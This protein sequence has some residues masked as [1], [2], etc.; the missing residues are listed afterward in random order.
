MDSSGNGRPG[1]GRW[2]GRIGLAVL[3]VL[4][5]GLGLAA[6]DTLTLDALARHHATLKAWQGTHLTAVLVGFFIAYVLAA[7]ISVPGIGLLTMAG[8]YLFGALTG[9]VM[10][11]AAATLGATGLFLTVRAGLG[12]RWLADRMDPRADGR[13]ARLSAE[14]ARNQIKAL[15]LLRLVPVV[16]FFVANTLPALL[17]VRLLPYVTTTAAGILPGTAVLAIAG[18]GL[19]E[20]VGAGGRPDPGALAPLFVMVPALVLATALGI[21]LLRR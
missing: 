11:V 12:P 15:L 7:L 14:L 20:V 17:G 8:G 4:S 21:R 18:V 6:Q 5:L 10:V 9:T 2:A 1:R 19:G 16:P 13:L 3:V